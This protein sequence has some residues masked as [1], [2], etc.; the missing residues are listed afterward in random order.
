MNYFLPLISF[1]L[2]IVLVPIVRHIAVKKDWIA[3]PS[4]ERWHKKPTALMG[5]IAI[6]ISSAIPIFFIANFQSITSYFAKTPATKVLPSL[7]A[8]TLL[9]MTI[10][11]VIGLVDDYFHIKPHV[12]L[13]GQIVVA[14]LVAFLGFRM[15]WFE[16]L[17]LDTL[18][19]IF[20]IVGITNAFNLIDNMD[21]LCAGVQP[22]FLYYFSK[23]PL[24][25]L[26]RP[27][28]SQGRY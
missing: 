14:S 24:Q 22:L 4:Q 9:G 3:Y 12:K 25:Y 20:W 23:V 6:Y 7:P 16:S 10:L 27:L 18:I 15:H 8:V 19:T 13:F 11:F 26:L 17:T 2:C 5:G 1:L 21:G 28:S